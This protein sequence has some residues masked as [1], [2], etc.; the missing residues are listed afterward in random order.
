[1]SVIPIST[2]STSGQSHKPVN[3]QNNTTGGEMSIMFFGHTACPRNLLTFDEQLIKGLNYETIVQVPIP[4]P[5]WTTMKEYKKLLP[6]DDGSDMYFSLNL[7][8]YTANQI[9]TPPNWD[10][11]WF[12]MY[13]RVHPYALTWEVKPDYACTDL[14]HYTVPVI[15][16]RNQ[17]YQP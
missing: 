12:F 13:G 14:Q 7:A 8:I 4:P 10:N 11:E 2:P 6:E 1:M 16:V 17:E 15:I 5:T 9:P 3:N